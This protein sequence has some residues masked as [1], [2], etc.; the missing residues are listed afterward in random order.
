M[1]VRTIV[2]LF[3]TRSYIAQSITVKFSKLGIFGCT[4]RVLAVTILL[5][6]TARV[7]SSK[8]TRVYY[9]YIFTTAIRHDGYQYVVVKLFLFNE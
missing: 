2:R 6:F 1:F 8:K 5:V 9:K 7:P 3:F 4:V